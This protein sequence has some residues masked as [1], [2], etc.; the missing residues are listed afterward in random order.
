MK[1]KLPTSPAASAMD[2]QELWAKLQK[3]GFSQMAFARALKISPQSV[4]SWI[5][6]KYPVPQTIAVLVNLMLKTKSTPED[7]KA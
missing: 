6:G 7:L 2:G 5:G 1:K 4:R 3:I